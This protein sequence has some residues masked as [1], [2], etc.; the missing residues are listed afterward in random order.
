[1]LGDRIDALGVCVFE[2][3]ATAAHSIA[4]ADPE[5]GKGGHSKHGSASH[6]GVYSGGFR[7]GRARS[8]PPFPLGD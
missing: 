8:A 2:W 3:Y 4:L 6:N 5:A 7:G 1:M